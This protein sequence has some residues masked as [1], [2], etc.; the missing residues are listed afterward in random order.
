MRPKYI[1]NSISFFRVPLA[2]TLIICFQPDIILL[3]IAFLALIA[4]YVS[5]LVDGYVARRLSVA[6]K[7]GQ[8]WDSLAD[9]AVY[10]G[11]VVAMNN[12][13]ILHPIIAWALILRDV[14]MYVSRIVYIE[15][16]DRLRDLK[17][18]SYAHCALIYS[19]ITLGFLEMY[20]LV[21]RGTFGSLLLVNIAAALTFIVGSVGSLRFV[22]MKKENAVP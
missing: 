17:A 18:Y 14:G 20:E 16:L 4:S 2:L 12:Q 1:A 3:R 15:K 19:T 10:I 13:G 9:K 11:A 22:L 5:D 8:L 7:E 21:R 6:S